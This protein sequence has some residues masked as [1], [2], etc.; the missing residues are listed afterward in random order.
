MLS[1]ESGEQDWMAHDC[2]CR[3]WNCVLFQPV[4]Y[5]MLSDIHVDTSGWSLGLGIQSP[6]RK[7]TTEAMGIG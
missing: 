4:Y 7:N 6:W 5:E 1:E 2:V 3:G